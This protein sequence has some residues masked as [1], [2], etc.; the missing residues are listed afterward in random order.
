MYF[1]LCAV[2]H[3]N[4]LPALRQS[5]DIFP[6]INNQ[7]SVLEKTIVT[8]VLLLMLRVYVFFFKGRCKLLLS[9]ATQAL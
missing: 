9:T 6:Q 8:Q 3:P 5:P 7:S 2:S 1:S 4:F